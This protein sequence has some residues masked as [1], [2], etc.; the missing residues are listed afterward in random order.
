MLKCRERVKF[1]VC[2]VVL[3][4]T[5]TEDEIFPYNAKTHLFTYIFIVNGINNIP[6]NLEGPM[7]AF[8]A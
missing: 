7:E 3:Q 8:Y 1:S 4:L 5:K 2:Y 6:M